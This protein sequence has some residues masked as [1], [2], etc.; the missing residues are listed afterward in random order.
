MGK[1]L[2]LVGQRF[3][4]LVV[5]ERIPS[6]P[7]QPL[8]MWR[9]RCDC[10]NI[11]DF[12]TGSLRSGRIHSC[13]CRKKEIIN[14]A[15]SQPN[16]PKLGMV[17]ETNISR[18]SSNKP[19]KNN[20]LGIRGVSKTKRGKYAAFIYYKGKR[21]YLGVYDTVDKAKAVYDDAWQER[22]E[23]AQKESTE[24]GN[25]WAGRKQIDLIGKTFGKLTVIEKAN[26]DFWK[27]R[28]E[29]GTECIKR[30]HYL[31][32]HSTLSCGC[33]KHNLPVIDLSGQHFGKLTAIKYIGYCK[34]LCKC[35]CGNECI[36]ASAHLK[37]G[38]TRSCGCIRKSK[39]K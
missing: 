37:S 32:N 28:C 5:L 25:S 33:M 35:D 27:C 22:I 6:S 4:S 9:C 23:E 29:C 31:V 16:K 21:Q 39:R 36:V 1:A 15:I 20:L 7:E 11:K 19:S 18:I 38:H 13:G 24:Q 3:H 17:N 8:V 2:D 26:G 30:Q 12:G 14:N 10:G 34:W